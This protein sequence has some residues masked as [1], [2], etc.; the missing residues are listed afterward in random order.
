MAGLHASGTVFDGQGPSRNEPAGALDRRNLRYRRHGY[1][2][3][4]DDG[5]GL[6][7]VFE[8]KGREVDRGSALMDAIMLAVDDHAEGMTIMAVIGCLE[9]AKIAVFDIHSSEA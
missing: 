1:D 8:G 4:A 2:C 7:R 6:M 3:S 9:L 5:V